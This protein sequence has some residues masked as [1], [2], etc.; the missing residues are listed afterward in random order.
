VVSS[1][2]D[3][4]NSLRQALG[5]ALRGRDLAAAAALRS[6]LSA[7]GNAEAV[8]PPRAPESPAV[9]GDGEVDGAHIAGAAAGLGAGEV[10][11]RR[12]SEADAAA[13]VRAEI[14][15]RQ[16]AAAD[17]ER[18]GHGDRAARLRREAEVLAAAAP[19]AAGYG[20]PPYRE[21]T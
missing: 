9:K 6:A 19:S 5:A 12:L 13:I 1:E 21:V 3:V 8:A 17:Y 14:D 18:A 11:R 16:A 15:E 10:P 20:R 2:T 4:Q 7:I